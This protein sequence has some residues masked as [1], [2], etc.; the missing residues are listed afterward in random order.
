MYD[1]TRI[2]NSQLIPDGAYPRLDTLA[3]HCSELPAFESTRPLASV[4]Q[5]SPSLEK[6]SG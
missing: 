5:S 4:D 1:F 6:I 2:V 3:L